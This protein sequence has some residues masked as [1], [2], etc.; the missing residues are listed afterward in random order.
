MRLYSYGARIGQDSLGQHRVDQ[1]ST[2]LIIDQ[3]STGLIIGQDSTESRSGYHRI[4]RIA[5]DSR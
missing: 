2:D 4:T 3:D 5:R 1:D